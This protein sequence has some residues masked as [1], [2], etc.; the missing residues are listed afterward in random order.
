MERP[1]PYYSAPSMGSSLNQMFQRIM[2]A[3]IIGVVVWLLCLLIAVILRLLKAEFAVALGGYASQYAGLIGLL[4]ALWHF[5][6]GG[7]WWPF[8]KTQS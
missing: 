4:A 2:R 6:A 3:V 7:A 5:F 1:R 8:S